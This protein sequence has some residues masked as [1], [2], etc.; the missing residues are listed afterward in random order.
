MI[1]VATHDLDLDDAKA[2]SAVAQQVLPLI[3]DVG[4]P[5]EREHYRQQLAR[6]LRIDER[7]LR[8][9]QLPP[10]TA[11]A[12]LPRRHHRRHRRMIFT[13]KAMARHNKVKKRDL[14]TAQ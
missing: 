6:A 14:F 3:N 1:G 8:L 7:T 2:K 5:V 9:V 11:R 13:M 10:E 4:D 12:S